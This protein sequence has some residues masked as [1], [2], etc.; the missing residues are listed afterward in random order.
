[1]VTYVATAGRPG[2]K[3]DFDLLWMCDW[4][5]EIQMM[6]TAIY[7]PRISV[8]ALG[9]SKQIVINEG[10]LAGK[11]SV[12]CVAMHFLRSGDPPQKLLHLTYDGR[13]P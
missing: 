5:I 3:W 6:A 11:S 9:V 1:M 2:K 4:L 10:S 7:Y 8:S 13:R 12:V